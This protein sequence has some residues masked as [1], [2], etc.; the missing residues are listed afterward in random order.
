MLTADKNAI[1]P[2]PQ[3][4]VLTDTCLIFFRNSVVLGTFSIS[5]VKI[6]YALLIF[7]GCQIAVL[8]HFEGDGITHSCLRIQVYDNDMTFV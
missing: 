1:P 2:H 7:S 6:S 4:K 8:S 3:G 5:P